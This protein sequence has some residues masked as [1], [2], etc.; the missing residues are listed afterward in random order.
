LL[1]AFVPKQ[2]QTDDLTSKYKIA[3][4]KQFCKLIMGNLM[5]KQAR[6]IKDIKVMIVK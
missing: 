6:G 1:F 5:P 4:L 2:K 3:V